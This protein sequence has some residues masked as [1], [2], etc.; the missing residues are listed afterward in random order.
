MAD[1]LRLPRVTITAGATVEVAPVLA[2]PLAFQAGRLIEAYQSAKP[3]AAELVALRDLYGF[4]IAE[5]QP[6]WTIIDHRGPI[7]PTTEGMYRL[8]LDV[9]LP[10]IAEWMATL[11][12]KETA[13]DKL[14]PPSPLRDQLNAKLSAKRKAA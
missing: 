14:V 8:P 9:S 1:D 7:Q 10:I 3:G 12:P 11:I 5:A 4:F 6:T 13:V 2:W